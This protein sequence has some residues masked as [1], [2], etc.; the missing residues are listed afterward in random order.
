MCSRF[1]AHIYARVCIL[2]TKTLLLF[3]RKHNFIRPLLTCAT[4]LSI[5][6]RRHFNNEL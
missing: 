3:T 6:K 4:L 5:Q 2:F 1:C